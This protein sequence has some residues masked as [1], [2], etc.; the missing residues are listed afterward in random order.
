[1]NPVLLNGLPIRLN[2]PDVYVPETSVNPVLPAMMLLLTVQTPE[3]PVKVFL[4]PALSFPV[5]VLLET[6]RVIL[7]MKMPPWPLLPLI[8]LLV[9]FSLPVDTLVNSVSIPPKVLLV[10][11]LSTIVVEIEPLPAM[12]S[13]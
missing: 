12:A 9:M 1:M 4:I 11:V 3:S 10:I 7:E 13:P 6:F 5:I 2:P 8:V